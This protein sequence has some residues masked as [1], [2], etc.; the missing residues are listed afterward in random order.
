MTDDPQAASTAS[1]SASAV[2]ELPLFADPYGRMF[3]ACAELETEDANILR[4]LADL[5][6]RPEAILCHYGSAER[7]YV[8]ELLTG[9]P[10][11]GKHFHINI[12]GPRFSKSRRP[13]HTVSP[14]QFQEMVSRFI[15]ER[16]HVTITGRF[17]V[18]RE[19]LPAG[20]LVRTALDTI[21]ATVS[22]LTIQ[23]TGAKFSIHGGS[24]TEV[25]WHLFSSASDQSKGEVRAELRT[26]QVRTVEPNYLLAAYQT[27][28]EAFGLWI[29]GETSVK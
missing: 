3:S 14:S 9:G 23:Q 13:S 25:E 28:Y 6:A 1:P 26:S 11:D 5:V 2:M 12:Y 4:L 16:V 29:L 24:V 19:S 8:A 27:A 17:A 20:G 22:A 21:R 15:G 7:P 18:P 10:R